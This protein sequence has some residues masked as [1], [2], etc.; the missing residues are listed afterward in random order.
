MDVCVY[1]ATS[2]GVIAANSTSDGGGAVYLDGGNLN[3]SKN[4]IISGNNSS[5]SSGEYN[6]GGGIYAINSAKIVINGG[7]ITNNS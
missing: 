5:G 4:A 2:G 1:G 6:G 7:Y 3:I